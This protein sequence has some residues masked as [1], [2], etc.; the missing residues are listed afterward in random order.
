MVDRKLALVFMDK[1]GKW[2]PPDEV[3]SDELAWG[4]EKISKEIAKRLL[5]K[6]EQR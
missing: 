5:L 2:Y 4:L 1:D 6:K 3:N